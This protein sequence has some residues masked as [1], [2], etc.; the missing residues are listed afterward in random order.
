M[1][2]YRSKRAHLD[3]AT[4]RRNAAVADRLKLAAVTLAALAV[5]GCSTVDTSYRIPNWP[6]DMRV[7][8]HRV[9][10]EEIQKRCA[11]YVG[12]WSVPIACAEWNI[13]RRECHIWMT[14]DAPRFVE[15]HERLHCEGYPKHR[16]G[17]WQ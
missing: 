10:A 11:R 4:A 12:T 5:V 17:I 7:I 1:V 16:I 14:P 3:E 15:R 9:S 6:A 2:W 13:A 8:E